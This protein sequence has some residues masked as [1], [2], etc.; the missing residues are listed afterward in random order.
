MSGASHTS[1]AVVAVAANFGAAARALTG[2]FQDETGNQITV[3]LGSSGTLY[4]QIVNGAPFDA[5]LSAD[6]L[7]PALL[8]RRGHAVAGT[9]FTYAVGRL[10]LWSRDSA[11]AR[12]GSLALDSETYRHLAIAMPATAPYGAA[13]EQVLRRLGL[14]DRVAGRLVRGE[15]IAQTYQFVATGNAELGFVALSQ[16]IERPAESYWLVPDSL[17]DPI[18]QQAVLLERGRHNAMALGFLEFVGSDR[19]AAILARFGYQRP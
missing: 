6:T 19:G 10:A 17:H 8:E 4:A 2:A 5:F 16:V 11:L 7:R 14:W 9:R 3:T 12:R 18:A 1:D 15:S 13:S